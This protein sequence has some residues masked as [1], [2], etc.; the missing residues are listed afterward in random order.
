[1]TTEASIRALDVCIQNMLRDEKIDRVLELYPS[2]SEELKPP[3]EAVQALHVYVASLGTSAAIQPEGREAFMQAAKSAQPKTSQV[4]ERRR[5]TVRLAWLAFI[6]LFLAAAIWGYVNANLALPGDLL[7]PVKTA[8]WQARRWG[9]KDPAKQLELERT[10][11]QARLE[12][13]ASLIRLGRQAEVSFAGPASQAGPGLL[14]VGAYQVTLPR[15]TRLIGEIQDGIWIEVNGKL[16]PGGN[17]LAEEVR[18]REYAI[19]GSLQ[20][21]S[22]T[23]LIVSGLPF[24]LNEKTLV[25]GAPMAGSE[26]KVVA[27][28]TTAD[29]LLARLVEAEER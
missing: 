25:H 26:V 29:E 24:Q 23:T 16:Q 7:Y 14:Q 13:I 3:L 15:E 17:I 4:D 8:I 10:I 28:R 18:P 11:D 1:M 19:S 12:D 27:L 6:F 22:P 2:L 21:I 20:Q 5:T 9:T